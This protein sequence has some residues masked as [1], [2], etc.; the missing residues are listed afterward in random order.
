MLATILLCR[1][2]TENS[3]CHKMQFVITK[4][5]L[6]QNSGRQKMPFV[7]KFSLPQN[8]GVGKKR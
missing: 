5:S 1:D 8:T 7:T 6:S 3:V 2:T 4:S